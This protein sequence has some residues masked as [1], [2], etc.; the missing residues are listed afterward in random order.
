MEQHESRS[1]NGSSWA[2]RPYSAKFPNIKPKASRPTTAHRPGVPRRNKP[3]PEAVRSKAVHL[4]YSAEELYD[5]VIEMKNVLNEVKEENH[6]LKTK[7]K[8]LE[9]E[10]RREDLDLDRGSI[11]ATLKHQLKEAAKVMEQREKDLQDLKKNTRA[12]HLAEIDVELKVYRDECTRLRRILEEAMEQLSQ[13]VVPVDLQERHLQ[14]I[15][16]FK[17][18]K[19]DHN[20]ISMICDELKNT[21]HSK[22][23]EDIFEALKRSLVDSKEDNARL[24][25]EN[26]RLVNALQ[27]SAQ[28]CPNC[29]QGEIN[30][31]QTVRDAESMFIEIWKNLEYRRLDP[32]GL[33]KLV[34]FNQEEVGA[35]GVLEGL[36]QID[37]ILNLI[38]ASVVLD[39][40]APGHENV[41]MQEFIDGLKAY[42]PKDLVS[43]KE[44]EPSLRH[45][46]MRLQIRRW[47]KDQVPLLF[48]SQDLMLN[49][50][51]VAEILSSEP[52]ELEQDDVM[53]VVEF[54]FV[55]DQ[56][57]PNELFIHRLM[58]SVEA[59]KVLSEEDERLL[60]DE[61]KA[62]MQN[63][64][65]SFLAK[66]EEV[67][68]GR[69]GVISLKAF[70]ELFG[71]QGL[72]DEL[73]HYLAL[74]C[75]TDQCQLDS[76]PY[77]SLAKAYIQEEPARPRSS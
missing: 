49:K 20:E 36:Q 27:M 74:I 3:R 62:L 46:S 32:D 65:G 73:M 8:Q 52:L 21:K 50:Q 33:W 37:V 48:V 11:V 17:A 40:L 38:E 77:T 64:I 19:R 75:Y 54:L 2:E 23:K 44:A 31:Q 58:L 76:V 26:Q 39:V 57:L 59:W 63:L 12:T 29:G 15:V 72:K 43:Y 60:D 30:P 51:T 71:E 61:L 45:F 10:N 67:D 68:T 56:L 35:Q 69:S 18:L 7:V 4:Q 66:C 70:K 13:G 42:R 53:T 47:S 9:K 22:K 28:S 6:K 16:Q 5:R 55:D 41:K 14:L 24:Y 34:G 25:E 1:E